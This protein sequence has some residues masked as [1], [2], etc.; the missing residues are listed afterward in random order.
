MQTR[1]TLET[2]PSCDAAAGIKVLDFTKQL[3]LRLER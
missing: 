2:V 1:Y 3:A